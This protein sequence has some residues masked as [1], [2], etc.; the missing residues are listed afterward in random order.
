[1]LHPAASTEFNA[2][3]SAEIGTGDPQVPPKKKK[4]FPAEAAAPQDTQTCSPS[5]NG[6]YRLVATQGTRNYACRSLYRALKPKKSYY[7]PVRYAL[8]ISCHSY[9]S[10]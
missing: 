8:A 9:F 6:K 2:E 7:L 5:R 10:K 4:A 3:K 1:M